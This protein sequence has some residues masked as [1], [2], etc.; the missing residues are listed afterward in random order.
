MKKNELLTQDFF[1]RDTREVARDLL[2]KI[3]Y[4]H[5]N[6]KIYRAIISETEAYHGREDLA[7]HC[8]RGITPRTKVMFDEPGKIYVYLIYGMYEMLNFVTMEKGF[9][10]AVLIRG[11]KNLECMD[12]EGGFKALDLPTDGPGKLTKRMKITRELNNK[13]LS[14]GTG[15]YVKE[16]GIIIPEDQIGISKRIG[17]DYA[18]EWKEKPWR[19]YI[20]NNRKF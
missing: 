6:G 4:H 5:Q 2:G 9:P 20:K 11:V 15:L 10:A 12:R 3:L 1:N 18:G 19:Y 13:I 7:C 17:V 14:P 16:E 8:S